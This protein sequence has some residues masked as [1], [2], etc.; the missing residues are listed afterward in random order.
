M[1]IPVLVRHEQGCP[2]R[3]GHSDAAKRVSDTYELHRAAAFDRAAGRWFAVALADGT[4]DHTLYDSKLDAVLHC[5]HDELRYAFI[6]IGPAAMSVCA[7]E[8]FM[9][10]RRAFADKGIPQADPDHPHGGLDVIRRLTVE[11]QR[12]L[13]GSI[14]RGGPAANLMYPRR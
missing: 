11:D 6:C 12:S 1:N 3:G 8:S 7:A 14:L 9:A 13:V 10:T 5:H 4:S 2:V